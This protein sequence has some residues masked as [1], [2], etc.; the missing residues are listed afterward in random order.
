MSARACPACGDRHNDSTMVNAAAGPVKIGDVGICI[1]CGALFELTLFGTR[2]LSQAERAD[3]PEVALV[4]SALIK[5]RGRIR[6][7]KMS[8]N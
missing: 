8:M 6:P 3:L 1:N 4:A 5:L 2:E 7:S